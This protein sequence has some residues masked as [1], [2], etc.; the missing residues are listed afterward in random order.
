MHRMFSVFKQAVCNSILV[1][2]LLSLLALP[3]LLITQPSFA[4][5]I[6]PAG[7]QLLHQ[8]LNQESIAEEREQ[9]YEAQIK[10]SEDPDK[11]YEDNLKEF[12]QENPGEG[13]VE[14]AVEGTK[15]L[16]NKVTK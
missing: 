5:P 7:Q 4:A 12:R 14:K 9:A 13:I 10:A 2:G 15:D 1:F 11:V 8:D 16:V 3:S 6:S